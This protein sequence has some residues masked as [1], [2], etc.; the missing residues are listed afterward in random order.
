MLHTGAETMDRVEQALERFAGK[1]WP[2]LEPLPEVSSPGPQPFPFDAMGPVLGA[3]GLAI[4]NDVQAPDALAG[5]SVLAAASLAAMP[6]ADVVMPHGQRAP[7]SLFILSGLG[8]G[9][10]KSAVDQVA[11]HEVEKV[12]REQAR[13]YL[14]LSALVA[15]DKDAA[16]PVPRSLTVGKFTVEGLQKMLKGQATVGLFTS[17]GGEILGGHSMRE[18]RRM[19]GVAWLLKAWSGETLDAMTSGDGLSMLLGRRA[20]MHV[21]V[22]P[23]LL[24]QLLCDPLAQ[25]Q[26]LLARCLIAQP[27]TLAGSRLFNGRDPTA[28][29]AVRA[30]NVIVAEM[31]KRQPS[32]VDG[33]DGFELAPRGM[34]MAPDARNLWI[35]FYNAVELAQGPGKELEHARAFASKAA[36]HAARLAGVIQMSSNPDSGVVTVDAMDGGMRIAEFYLSEHVRLTGAGMQER[37]GMHLAMLLDWMQ[38]RGRSVAHRDVLQRVTSPLRKLKAEGIQSLLDELAQRGYIRRN[39]D[40]WEVRPC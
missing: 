34:V 37:G 10:R 24:R 11:L 9:D 29:D 2:K 35:E 25:G 28:S 3:A 20:A 38:A 1:P 8:S 33:G 19:A 27:D 26:G 15:N 31:L 18:D 22:Q 36:E 32:T 12:R 4:S 16:K 30:Y 23:V 40:T 6:H 39:G 7:L 21:L 14:R 5:G 13:D 17:E